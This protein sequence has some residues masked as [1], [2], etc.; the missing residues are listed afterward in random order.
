METSTLALTDLPVNTIANNGIQPSTEELLENEHLLHQSHIVAGLG[1]YALDVRTGLWRSSELMDEIF[2]ID[3][4]Y[5]HS[6][7]GWV[8]LIHPD[9]RSMMLDYFQGEVLGKRQPFNKEYR[10][11]KHNDKTER[12]L[13]GWGK[14]EFDTQGRPFKMI[15]IIQDITTR[16]RTEDAL[17]ESEAKFAKVF[18]DAPAWISI[19]DRETSIFLDINERAQKASGFSREEIIGHT[20]TELE[21]I[22]PADQ[23]QLKQEIKKLGKIT[24]MEMS[25]RVKNGQTLQGWVTGEIIVINGR[26]ALLTVIT[27]ITGRKEADAQ[28]SKQMAELR[29]WQAVTLGREGRVGELKRE[30]NA[31]AARLGLQPPYGSTEDIARKENR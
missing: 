28:L 18:R 31:L 11:L 23:E 26:S 27:D 15:G 3:T 24:G 10:I 21:W 16:K 25:F 7:E 13:H 4:S 8:A 22:T 17:R 14:L 12:W 30:V 2:G 20:P 19:T 6:I 29:R 1:T 5:T 9:D